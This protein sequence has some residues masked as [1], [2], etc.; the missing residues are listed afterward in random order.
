MRTCSTHF[1]AT[2]HRNQMR[3]QG[4]HLLRWCLLAVSLTCCG[5]GYVAGNYPLYRM[6][7]A[8][9]TASYQGEGFNFLVHERLDLASVRGVLKGLKSQGF[10]IY[11]P[12]IR[13]IVAKRERVPE[14]LLTGSDGYVYYRMSVRLDSGVAL[15]VPAGC[16]KLRIAT[17]DGEIITT[18]QG[19]LVEDTRAPGGCRAD[20]VT[21]L[22]APQQPDP[23]ARLPCRSLLIRSRVYGE[24]VGLE[25]DR[26]RLVVEYATPP[27][28][29]ASGLPAEPDVVGYPA[30][31]RRR[32]DD[33]G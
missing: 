11:D 28:T 21:R 18:D 22:S 20:P 29:T 13:Q 2:N 9:V 32:S 14:M 3:L 7:T 25:P 24:I 33:P 16:L 15:T 5:C 12:H 31:V 8:P 26:S 23:G 27:T 19:L 4:A 1:I 10:S 30:P 6:R 17:G